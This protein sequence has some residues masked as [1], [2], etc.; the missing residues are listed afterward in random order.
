M[1]HTA[2]VPVVP[3][4]SSASSS[5]RPAR[6]GSPDEWYDRIR[7]VVGRLL[8]ADR[9]QRGRD[10]QRPGGTLSHAHLRALFVLM[11]DHEATAGTLAKAADLNPA[12]VTAMIDQLEASG[13][14]ER[15]RDTHDRRSVLISLTDAGRRQVGEKDRMLRARAAEAFADVTDEELTTA[16]KV[17]ERIASAMESLD[18]VPVPEGPPPAAPGPGTA[19]A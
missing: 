18:D 11:A 10:Q 12:S 16:I 15:R 1:S 17:M 4:D 2:T 19:G 8:A 13:L 3:F 7:T 5:S 6:G 14:V 9:R